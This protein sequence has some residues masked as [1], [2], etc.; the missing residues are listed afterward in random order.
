MNIKPIEDVEIDH[1]I[2]LMG[3]LPPGDESLRSRV[4]FAVRRDREKK[5][6]RENRNPPVPLYFLFDT[7]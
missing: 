4:R 5:S 7:F 1:R 6:R 3:I 2:M